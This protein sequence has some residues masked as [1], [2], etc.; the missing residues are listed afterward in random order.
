MSTGISRMLQ[1]VSRLPRFNGDLFALVNGRTPA[2][3]ELRRPLTARVTIRP[4][5]VEDNSEFLRIV[6]PSSRVSDLV[7]C[8]AFGMSLAPPVYTV[9]LAGIDILFWLL[10]APLG[11]LCLVGLCI[12]LI[13]LLARRT[14]TLLPAEGVIQISYGI[15]RYSLRGE[16]PLQSARFTRHEYTV[17]VTRGITSGVLFDG[18]CTVMSCAGQSVVI[19]QSK[20]RKALVKAEALVRTRL[21]REIVQS[22]PIVVY[23]SGY[24]A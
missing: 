12:F 6:E 10:I 17:H 20:D 9:H 4:T 19:F 21:G 3:L 13:L 14:F 2:R 23:L 8:I 22:S 11:G 5:I 24:S 15:G 18:W 7:G 16:V 1:L